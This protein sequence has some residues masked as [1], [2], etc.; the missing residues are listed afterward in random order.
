MKGTAMVVVATAAT[1]FAAAMASGLPQQATIA[2]VNDAGT[3]VGTGS[4]HDGALELQL[5]DAA[6]GFVGLEVTALDGS[7]TWVQGVV[8]LDG[9]L[10]IVA[11]DGVLPAGEFAARYALAYELHS[12][13]T[14]EARAAPA[15]PYG[16]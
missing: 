9:S 1:L 10:H 4:I 3:L 14:V 13:G 12:R 5:A 8:P 16:W 7:T 11:A 15:A 6:R 2:V